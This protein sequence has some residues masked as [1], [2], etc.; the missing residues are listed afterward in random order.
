M[1]GNFDDNDRIS[2]K[3]AEKKQH[4]DQ[5]LVLLI[6]VNQKSRETTL[7]EE[8][9]KQNKKKTKTI[10]AT[11]QTKNISHSGQYKLYRNDRVLLTATYF[12]SKSSIDKE[13][14]FKA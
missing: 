2:S 1:K 14:R 3:D 13:R 7:H 9:K 12:L 4:L 8:K 10:E 5:I 11:A 6:G